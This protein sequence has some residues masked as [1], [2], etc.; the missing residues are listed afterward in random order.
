MQADRIPRRGSYPGGKY[1]CFVDPHAEPTLTWTEAAADVGA[2]ANIY[3]EK[4]ASAA[5]SLLRQWRC[6]L[7]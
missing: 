5:A 4:R 7:R 2:T 1:F 3:G 6:C